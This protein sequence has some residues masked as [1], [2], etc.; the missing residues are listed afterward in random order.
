MSSLLSSSSLCY[1]TLALHIFDCNLSLSSS[2]VRLQAPCLTLIVCSPL[3]S[4]CSVVLWPIMALM[5]IDM[6]DCSK[7][8][9]M[10]GIKVF[11]STFVAYTRLADLINNRHALETHMAANG[12]YVMDGDDIILHGTDVRLVNGVM[13]VCITLRY[14]LS[15]QADSE[16]ILIS[17]AH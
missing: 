7:V 14:C 15:L 4:I 9:E 12:T 13:Q 3:Q 5:G 6:A 8:G 11:L 17:N 16:P 1:I 10:V 2:T